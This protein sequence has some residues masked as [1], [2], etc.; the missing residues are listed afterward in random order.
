MFP[1]YPLNCVSG[2][3]EGRNPVPEMAKAHYRLTQY[4]TK[5]QF[6]NL[7]LDAETA[8]NKIKAMAFDGDRLRYKA[9]NWGDL[10]IVSVSWSIDER[11]DFVWNVFI[12]ECAADSLG[13]LMYE[14]MIE[15]KVEVHCEW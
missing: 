11:D 10:R 2:V 6:A 13:E 1:C 9:V 3:A 5:E 14:L 8:L 15:K 7:R 12:E 4:P